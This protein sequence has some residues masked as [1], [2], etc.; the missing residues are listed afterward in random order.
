MRIATPHLRPL[1]LR[2]ES[3]ERLALFIRDSGEIRCHSDLH[4]LQ[5]E[6][7]LRPCL[8]KDLPGLLVLEKTCNDRVGPPRGYRVGRTDPVYS[9]KLK[10]WREGQSGELR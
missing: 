4:I 5:Q 7:T 9:L 10:Q 1:E 6:W 3:Q 8:Q 2:P